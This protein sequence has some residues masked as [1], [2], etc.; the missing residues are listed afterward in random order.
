ML[1]NLEYSGFIRINDI[2]N[3]KRKTYQLSDYYSCFYFRFIKDNYGKDEHFWSNTYDNPARRAW[4]GLTFEQVCKDHVPQIKR[5]LG[6]SGVAS[7]VSVWSSKGDDESKGAQI[8]LLIDRK[9]RVINICEIK[10]STSEYEIDKDADLNL[11]NKID[12]F[13]RDSKSKDSIQLT[14]ITTYGVHK[15]KYSGVVNNQVV[16]DDLFQ[17]V[18]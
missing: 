6:I 4:T 5:K 8:D 10:Y 12:A 9:D 17:D 1:E 18:E 2:Y 14:M 15:N 16:M 11:R 3:T 7:S 13:V